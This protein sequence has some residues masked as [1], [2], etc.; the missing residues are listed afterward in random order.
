MA[1][2]TLS[3]VPTLLDLGAI[4]GDILVGLQKDAEI[5]VFFR[6]EDPAGFKAALKKAAPLVTTT[7]DVRANEA[8]IARVKASGSKKRLDILCF[9]L[10]FTSAGLDAL[11]GDGFS[12]G[13]AGLDA[14]F[15]EGAFTRVDDLADAPL[16]DWIPGFRDDTIHGVFFLTGP[17][18]PAGNP[19]Q[20]HRG[21]ILA[22]FGAT[23]SIVHEEAG[24]VR[25]QRGHEHFGFEDGVSQPGVRGLTPNQNPLDENQG[26]PGQD[27]VQPGEF[28]FGY[29]KQNPEDRTQPLPAPEP[30]LPWMRNGSYV[31]FRRL[32]QKV[33][34]FRK[35]VE[36]EA[37]RLEMDKDLLAA[38]MVGRWPS[39]APVS[40][41]PL[42]DDPALGANPML[43]NAFEFSGDPFQRRCPY[44]AHI[45][46][47]YPR[48]D[49][50]AALGEAGEAGVQTR[51]LRRAGIPFGPEISPA[52]EE[53][54]EDT[55]SRGL[56]FVSYQTSII[57]QFEF[58]QASWAN[59]P[60]FVFAK[61]RPRGRGG[62]PVTVG[63]DPLVGQAPGLRTMDEPVP[64][65]PT[66]NVESTLEMP[67]FFVVTTASTYA[68]MPSID[69]LKCG[70]LVD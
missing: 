48:D 65:Y 64:N 3:P 58:V 43:N 30:P 62:A 9:N 59:N 17:G 51:R 53:A 8:D 40:L 39:G 34:R 16:G 10:G 61:T 57:D 2:Q 21:A 7:S 68:F 22:L 19:L 60:G 45:R 49:L 41:A 24:Q 11:L 66:G 25:P 67:E 27:L 46:K 20:G 13:T 50:D 28:V 44:G 26:L 69:A 37:A 32:E 23:L 36:A 56:M 12:G 33:L 35:F 18:D 42:Q 70:P 5:F 1:I 38:R 54:G 55:G 31:V 29:D 47:T 14:A 52:E 4:Q 6:I 63:H 15:V